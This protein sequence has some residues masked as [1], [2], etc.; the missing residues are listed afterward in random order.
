MAPYDPPNA[1]YT[2]VRI[3]EYIDVLKFI[4]RGGH[5]LKNITERSGVQY[6]WVDMERNV[7]EI[8]GWESRLARAI[9]LTKSRIRK[10]T[11]VW[12]PSVFRDMGD[13]ELQQR[14]NVKCWKIGSH[15]FYEVVGHDND[16]NRFFDHV[17]K[18][19]PYNPYMT[20]IKQRLPGHLL[21]SRF[22]SCD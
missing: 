8:W 22:S 9:A 19:Y 11:C 14:L 3:P 2:E 21:I 5:H 18:N 17:V 12:V 16:S 10:L 1:F 13:K 6:I 15:T 4:G 7:V 20:Q